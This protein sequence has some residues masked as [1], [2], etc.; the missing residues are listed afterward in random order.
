LRRCPAGVL[1]E[2]IQA[3]CTQE[4]LGKIEKDAEVR[5]APKWERL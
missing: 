3:P 4:G 2:E 1:L 5:K